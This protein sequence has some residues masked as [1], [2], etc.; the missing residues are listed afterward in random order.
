MARVYEKMQQKDSALKYY[1]YYAKYEKY[2]DS[3]KMAEL[4][5]QQ[6]R[7][8]EQEK[9]YSALQQ[10]REARMAEARKKWITFGISSLA[11]LALLIAGAIYSRRNRTEYAKISKEYNGL[12]QQVSELEKKIEEETKRGKE[13]SLRCQKLEMELAQFEYR[14][15]A[16]EEAT[17][18]IA[19]YTARRLL[20]GSTPE[21]QEI[22]K[23]LSNKC[24]ITETQITNLKQAIE[25]EVPPLK[26][27]F[28]NPS[29]VLTQLQ[30]GVCLL[31]CA[32]FQPSEIACLLNTTPQTVSTI[33]LRLGCSIFPHQCKR[34]KDFDMCLLNIDKPNNPYFMKGEEERI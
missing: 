21:A 24:K 32:S 1:S 29:I 13:H 34:T 9:L 22:R 28:S 19:S 8:F 14:K 26:N 6:A 27:F 12:R 33:R 15:K 2:T 4:L 5:Q 7:S 25:R 11:I 16:I 17:P 10:A 20:I 31:I 18:D 3:L 23:S 30:Q